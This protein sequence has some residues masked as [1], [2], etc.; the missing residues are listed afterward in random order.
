MEAEG[1]LSCHSTDG[2]EVAG[3]TLKGI[4]GRTV[5]RADGSEVEADDQYLREAILDPEKFIVV[6][7]DPIMPSYGH[8][9]EEQVQAMIDYMHL[10]GAD[11]D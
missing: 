7:Y 5:K 6:G 10:L 8:L 4:F 1:C 2:S 11:H 9:S 3:P